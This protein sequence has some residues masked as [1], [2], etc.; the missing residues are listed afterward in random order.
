MIFDW[1]A[2]RRRDKLRA[3]PF[4]DAWRGFVERNVPYVKTL[5]PEQRKDL[6]GYI[7]IFVAEKSMEGCGGLELTD[8][9]R[10]TI[11]AQACLLLLGR[12]RDPYPAI[13]VI[14][15]YPSAFKSKTTNAAGGIV[16]EGE[17]ARLG[18]ASTRGVLVLSWDDVLKGARDPRD[19]HNV[20]IHEFAHALDHEDGSSDG[21]PVLS[22]RQNYAPWAEVL[23]REYEQLLD[24]EARHRK[25]IVDKYGATNPAEFF[26]VVT[27]TFF[28]KPVQL[29]NNHPE[30]YEQLALYYKQDPAARQAKR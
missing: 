2:K 15:V 20:V 18:E 22:Q 4:P 10:V 9:I 13:D 8:E 23:G 17:Q 21:A 25:T 14:L 29:K 30:L 5:S 1:F 19:R 6:D 16:V 12:D 28:E 26:A 7:Q 24:D 3:E 27:E 11:A